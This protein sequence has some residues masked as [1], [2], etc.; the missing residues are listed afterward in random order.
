MTLTTQFCVE[1]Q[2]R[3]H[4]LPSA[5]ISL[6]FTLQSFRNMPSACSIPIKNLLWTTQPFVRLPLYCCKTLFG[7]FF[8]FILSTIPFLEVWSSVILLSSINSLITS[9]FLFCSQSTTSATGLRKC[10]SAAP[11]QSLCYFLLLH[12]LLICVK[13]QGLL[14]YSFILVSLRVLYFPRNAIAFVSVGES[15]S[16]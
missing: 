5:W 15:F 16:L 14:L 1:L 7:I 10:I 3:W 13:E 12:E 2:L 6:L 4:A 11:V 9:S 8:S